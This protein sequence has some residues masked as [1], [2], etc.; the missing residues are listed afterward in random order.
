M[1]KLQVAMT[2]V[3][4]MRETEVGEKDGEIEQLRC[5][6]QR[7]QVRKP[8]TIMYTP[9]QTCSD[10]HA[11]CITCRKTNRGCMQAE[12]EALD[13]QL[14]QQDEE[15]HVRAAQIDRQQLKRTTDIESKEG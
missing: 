7:I 3:L 11:Y 1:A 8:C 12:V 9:L 15:L 14:Q 5:D 10:N 4:R 6:L 13:T 2:S